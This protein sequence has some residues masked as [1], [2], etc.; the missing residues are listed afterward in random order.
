MRLLIIGGLIALLFLA[1]SCGSNKATRLLKK[2]E[3]IK[4]RAIAAGAV[5]TEQID[6]AAQEKEFQPPTMT[7]EKETVYIP[8]DTVTVIQDNIVVRT[9]VKPGQRIYIHVQAKPP[10]FKYIQKYYITKTTKIK[11]GKT[12]FEYWSG[13]VMGIVIGGIAVFLVGFFRG[14]R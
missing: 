5:V 8:G 14:R 2:S 1:S 6:S 11:A 12:L 3:R 9:V 4:D 13:F 7:A 10:K